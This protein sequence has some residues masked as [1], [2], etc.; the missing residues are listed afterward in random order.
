[1]TIVAHAYDFVVGVDT[2]TKNHVLAIIEAHTG[3]EIDTRQ[4]PATTA[5]FTRAVTFI[6]KRTRDS[7]RVLI[8][9]EGTASYGTG[10]RS[11]LEQA[12]L[13]VVEAPRSQ[14]RGRKTNSKTDYLDAL[15]IAQ[16][17]LPVNITKLTIPRQGSQ[18]E[19]LRIL[20]NA[21]EHMTRTCTAY[22]NVLTALVRCTNLGIDGRKPLTMRQIRE[23]S[24]ISDTDHDSI[25]ALA[26]KEEARRLA[27]TILDLK[28][29]LETNKHKLEALTCELAPTLTSMTG[30]GPV[31]AAMLIVAFS[32]VGRIPTEAGFA[33]LAGVCPIPA[34]SGNTVRHRL[35]RG[36]DRTLNKALHTIII[37]RIKLDPD[38]Q[39]Y[40]QRRLSEG[41]TK[42]EIIRILKRYLARNIYRTLATEMKP[43]TENNSPMKAI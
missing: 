39:A 29:Q 26:A 37:V 16:R 1:M 35:N 4:F 19:A 12:G 21:R 18:R 41:K 43:Q 28:T 31:T 30:I 7:A 3:A 25:E 23:L 20:V 42:K 8:S 38:T 27:L 14:V 11:C 34:S 33:A 2:H 15:S 9:M 17:T 10:L 32:H 6:R 40:M 13:F 24:N 22:T 36:G 5:G